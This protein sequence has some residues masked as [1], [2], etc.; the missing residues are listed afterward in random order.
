MACPICR[1]RKV[2]SKA[3]VVLILQGSSE[4][5]LTTTLVTRVG[6]KSFYTHFAPPHPC[7]VLTKHFHL[8]EVCILPF[9]NIER[10]NG[11]VDTY[12]VGITIM[13]SC[14]WHFPTQFVHDCSL[15]AYY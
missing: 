7:A 4:A 15:L 12:F 11:G 1:S 10:G 13:I 9:S 2:L 8:V 3:K 5:Q 14:F 6:K